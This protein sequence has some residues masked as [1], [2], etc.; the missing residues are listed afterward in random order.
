M[1]FD[2]TIA[3][4][5]GRGRRF[6]F[7]GVE[8]TI[9]R[10]P[11]SDLLLVDPFVSR[12]HARIC[13]EG[14]G[15]V[16]LDAGS[17]NGTALNGAPIRGAAALSPGDRIGVGPVVFEFG[18]RRPVS[19]RWWTRGAAG[20][21]RVGLALLALG[22]FRALPRWAW[23]CAA[24]G[25]GSCLLAAAV[26]SVHGPESPAVAGQPAAPPVTTAPVPGPA[27][28]GASPR[29]V[30]GASG[31]ARGWYERGLRKL[32]ERRVAPRN[33]YDAWKSFTAAR[34]LL[35]RLDP[36]PPLD[37]LPALIEA[38]EREL[39][40]WCRKLLFTARRFERYGEEQR[41]QAVYREVLLHFPGDDPSG[42]RARAQEELSTPADGDGTGR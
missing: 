1:P 37:A 41:A 2:L 25:A 30:A 19:P 32:E 16:L 35:G 9:G 33:L 6:R 17:S 28:T 13:A 18:P 14:P 20:T 4:G 12:S 39:G 3:E 15:H 21:A 31:E 22:R 7:D 23:T 36:A 8:V 24:A 26:A 5:T 38:A 29:D 10:A 11:S 42:C 40:T 34:G 27:E